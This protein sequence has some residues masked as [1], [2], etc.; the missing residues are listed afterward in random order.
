MELK[1][2][3]L[4]WQPTI[5]VTGESFYTVD[6]ISG[7]IQAQRDVWDSISDNKYYSFEGVAYIVRSLA[8]PQVQNA[9]PC[10]VKDA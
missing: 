1:F 9:H 4:P 8:N 6:N 7:K 2:R 5:I 10:I 3:L